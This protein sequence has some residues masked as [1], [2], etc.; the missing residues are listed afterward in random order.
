MKKIRINIVSESEISV[1][2]HGVHT[3]Y[4]EMCRS[5]EARDDVEVI[6]GQFGKKIDC[7]IIHIHTV[8][9][10]MYKKLAQKGPKKVIT[11]HLVPDSF[12]GSLLFARA[13][14]P[15]AKGYLKWFY[16]RA[17]YLLPVSD[18]TARDLQ[19]MKVKAPSEVMYNSID[20]SRYKKAPRSRE[21][22]REELGIAKGAFVVIGA[23]Q[24][25]PRKRVSDM[26]AV[27]KKM[28]DVRFVWVGGMPFGG[29]AADNAKMKRMME[30]APANVKFAG[31]VPLEDIGSYYHA[32]DAFWLPS[33]QETFGLVVVEAAASGLP[34]I[35]RDIPD[36]DA[37]FGNDALKPA[38]Q[39]EY[40]ETIDRLKDDKAFYKKWQVG[41][42]RIAQRFDSKEAAERLVQIYRDLL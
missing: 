20:T 6:R 41:A 19:K 2:G 34:I 10:H 27:A 5:L 38:T 33:I 37:T 42:Q 17:D 23:G 16:D 40:I 3:A 8:G 28:P 18:E 11:A 15:L 7:D 12:V 26:L 32:A 14:K 24:V 25:Q 13:W 29:L 31:I 22:V 36:Y 4:E 30:N 21:A 39:Q 1:Q 9:P 35:L